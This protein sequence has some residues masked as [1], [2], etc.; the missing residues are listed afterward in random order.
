MEWLEGFIN[1][2]SLFYRL[3]LSNAP[4]SVLLIRI[5]VGC[6]FLS[7]GIQKFL[8]P[9]ALGAGRFYEIGL[10]LPDLLA[11]LVGATEIVCGVL[12]LSGFFTRIASLPL[13]GIMLTAVIT[14]KLPILVSDGFWKMAHESRTDWSMLLG[15]IFLLLVG[16]GPVSMDAWLTG[17]QAGPPVASPSKKPDKKPRR[18]AGKKTEAMK[19]THRKR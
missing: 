10:P 12:L 19:L 17:K 2:M 6:V 14:T 4:A 3:C 15:A 16:A 18:S 7:E 9:A 5:M 11:P 8:F 13:I 1:L